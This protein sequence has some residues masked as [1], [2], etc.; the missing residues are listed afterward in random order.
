MVQDIPA[1]RCRIHDTTLVLIRRWGLGSG[2]EPIRLTYGDYRCPTRNCGTRKTY[3][4]RPMHRR[5]ATRQG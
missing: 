3:K 5:S 4:L 2:F 1:R